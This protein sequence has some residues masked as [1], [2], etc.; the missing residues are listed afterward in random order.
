VKGVIIGSIA[1]RDFDEWGRLAGMVSEA[2][3]HAIELNLSCPHIEKGKMGRAAASDP[4]VVREII[5]AVKSAVKVPV[6]GKLTP[7]GANPADL[8]E[9]MASAGVDA[10][11]STARFQGLVIDVN[12]MRP[13]SWGGFGGY[14]GPWQLPISLAWTA[15]IAQKKLGIPIIGSG[16]VS[17]GEDAVAML[18]AGAD[19]VQA[20]TAVMLKGW[21]HVPLMLA[22]IEEWMTA[23]GFAGIAEF[24]GAVT[25]RII[26]LDKLSRAKAFE[27]RI[28]SRRCVGCGACVGSCPYDALAVKAKKAVVDS[29]LCD[30]CGLCASI[31]PADAIRLAR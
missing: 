7:Q 15:R 14:G 21:K 26:P 29:V 24:R 18:L 28:D 30:N 3:A 5:K 2:G 20:C 13:V 6:I 19:A 23:H 17:S 22:E 10:V 16:G 31:C 25:D 27:V 4:K 1:G 11:V 8:A 12:T 9:V